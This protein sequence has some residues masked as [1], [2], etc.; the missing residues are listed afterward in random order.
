MGSW[1]KLGE[2]DLE[3]GAMLQVLA[4]ESEGSVF[5]DGFGFERLDRPCLEDEENTR[6]WHENRICN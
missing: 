4:G 5:A 3:P 6:K 2:F 1:R